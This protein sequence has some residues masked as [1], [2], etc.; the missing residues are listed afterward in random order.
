MSVCT[1]FG[2]RDCYGLDKA[3][4]QK[5]IEEQILRGVDTFYV[6][7]QGHFDSMVLACLRNLQGIYPHICF[8]VVLAY[9]P[10]AGQAFDPYADCSIIPEG[11]EA[12][13][14]KF[15][16]ERRNRW[17]LH[18]A[19]CCICYVNHSWGGAYKFARAAKRHGLTVVN[20]GNGGR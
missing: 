19:D 6:G 4:L 15:A 14:P 8:S 7:H 1:F 18:R 2:H 20:L 11:L 5:A 10:A 17:M 13:L 9:M 16:I 12:C 3:V